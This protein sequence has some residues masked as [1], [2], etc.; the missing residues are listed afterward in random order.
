MEKNIIFTKISIKFMLMKMLWD[1]TNLE[2]LINDFYNNQ[3]SFVGVINKYF[4]DKEFLTKEAVEMI[5]IQIFWFKKDAIGLEIFTHYNHKNQ[6]KFI[7]RIN[8]VSKNSL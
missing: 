7:K 1:K 3:L 2:P 8:K 6:N 4:E 5:L